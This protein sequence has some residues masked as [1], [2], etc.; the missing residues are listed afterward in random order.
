MMNVKMV[1]DKMMNDKKMGDKMMNDKTVNTCI[2]HV[3]IVKGKMAFFELIKRSWNV[4]FCQRYY[5]KLNYSFCDD[6]H[7]Y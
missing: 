5:F 1:N 7:T 6:L 2:S 3:K 4:M